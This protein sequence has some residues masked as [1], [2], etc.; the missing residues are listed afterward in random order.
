MASGSREDLNET[1]QVLYDTLKCEICQSSLKAGKTRWYRC[2][3]HHQICQTCKEVT[4]REKCACLTKIL[5]DHCPVTEKLLKIK[6]MRFSC[7]NESRGCTEIFGEEDM[8]IHEF[9][10]IYRIVECPRTSCKTK[11]QFQE[12]VEHMKRMRCHPRTRHVIDR[13]GSPS[14]F[15]NYELANRWRCLVYLYILIED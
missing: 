8:N 4:K 6:V 13:S 3:N 14:T 5:K 15:T 11:V 1:C 9:E 10:C 2:Q 7:M 12:L